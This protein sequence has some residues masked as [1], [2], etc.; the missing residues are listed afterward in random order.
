[1]GSKVMGNQWTGLALYRLWLNC[2]F[3]YFGPVAEC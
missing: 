1:M 3:S 2:P